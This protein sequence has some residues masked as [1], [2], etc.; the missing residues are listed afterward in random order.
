MKL[1][2]AGLFLLLFFLSI[3]A[4]AQNIPDNVIPTAI[5]AARQAI[6]SLG[7]PTQ[8]RWQRLVESSN[9]S[10]GCPLVQ[11]ST[12]LGRSVVVYEVILFFEDNYSVYVSS[13]A[14]LYQL[15]DSKFPQLTNN[16]T[17]TAPAITPVVSGTPAGVPAGTVVPASNCVARPLFDDVE[18][19]PLPALSTQSALSLQLTTNYT[20]VERT[21]NGAWYRLSIPNLVSDNWVPAGDIAVSGVGCGTLPIFDDGSAPNV[22]R[23]SPGGEFS[24]VRSAPTTESAVISTIL[25]GTTHI[26]LASNAEGTWF[27]IEQGWVATTVSTITGNCGNLPVAQGVSSISATGT[28]ITAYAC[29]ENTAAYLPTRIQPGRATARVIAGGAPNRLRAEP[30]LLGALLGNAQPGRTFDRVIEG[31]VCNDGYTWWRVE[32]DGVIGWT[33]ESNAEENDYYIEPVEGF[34]VTPESAASTTSRTLPMNAFVVSLAFS[35]DGQVLAAAESGSRSP[36]L[37]SLSDDQPLKLTLLDVANLFYLTYHPD[38]TLLVANEVGDIRFWLPDGTPLAPLEGVLQAQ[39]PERF[40]LSPDGFLIARRNCT[41]NSLEEG[42]LLGEVTL[43]DLSTGEAVRVFEM[44]GEVV[45]EVAFSPDG[46]LMATRDNAGVTLWDVATGAQIGALSTENNVDGMAFVNDADSTILAVATCAVVRTDNFSA[47]CDQS[48]VRLWDYEAD[49]VLAAVP[50]PQTFIT[51]IAA[52]SSEVAI[53][54]ESGDIMFISMADPSSPEVL[55][56]HEG[57]VRQL[58]YSP[59]G[60][61]L[62]SIAQEPLVYLS[63]R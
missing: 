23:L 53:G 6:P 16:I 63:E 30:S 44:P 61:L 13:D 48:E 40:A 52:S 38:G 60:T 39:F 11:T 51:A 1:R 50:V 28:P 25:Q 54:T 24:N 49:S 3:T 56:E 46:V 43:L 10:L 62:A 20:V 15:C 58:V 4:F 32:I 2:V 12:P 57:Q 41:N 42:C 18:A 33:V 29:P 36:R 47:T 21:A 19:Y 55:R 35:P 59:D 37:F 22:C 31:P 14:T 26:V 17:P 45:F 27:L 7:Q 9:S 8:W 34:E 5:N